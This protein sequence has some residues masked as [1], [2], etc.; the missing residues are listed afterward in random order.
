M[1]ETYRAD[2]AVIGAG[3]AGLAC[4]AVLAGRGLE[5]VVLEASDHY[6][7]GVSSRSSEVIHAGLYYPPGSLKARLCVEGRRALYRYLEAHAVAH[8]KCGKLIVASGDE[9]GELESLL[10]RGSENGAEALTGLTGDEARRMEP[11]L[12]AGITAAIHSPGTGIFDTHGFMRSLLGDLE[13]SGG[14][15]ALGSPVTGGERT[16]TGWRLKVGGET[17]VSLETPRLINA[18]GLGAE[19]VARRLE[20]LAPGTI[21]RTH[22]AKG[23]YCTL[24][25]SAPFQRLIYP[26]PAQ[27]GLGVHLTL[28]LSGRARFGPDIIPVDKPDYSVE[29][30]I[31]PAF[32]TAIRRYWPGLP[33][34]ALTPDYAG[35][36]PKLHGPGEPSADFRID[37]EHVHGAPGLVNLFGIESPGLTA[38]LA[39]AGAVSEKLP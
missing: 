3:A 20:G 32:E 34:G 7:G 38:T 15:L 18:A 1:S 25:G 36:R 23:R 2:A 6:G 13:D 16:K 35:V 12:S 21:P 19:A 27:G 33:A 9:A 14:R 24:Q 11:A 28:D 5:T 17:P 8:R 31:V 22:F 10:A 30:E 29:P 39:I 4:A 37:G 26:L